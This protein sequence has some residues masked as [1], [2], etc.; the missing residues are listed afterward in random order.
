M[1]ACV[2]DVVTV[3][4]ASVGIW[5][6]VN[7]TYRCLTPTTIGVGGATVTFSDMRLEAYMP[8]NELSPAGETLRMFLNLS[9]QLWMVFIYL[10]RFVFFTCFIITLFTES[11]CMADQTTTTAP[12]TTTSTTTPTTPEPTPEPTPPGLPERGSYSVKTS[13]GTICLLALMGLQL[14]VSYVSQSQNKVT[15]STNFSQTAYGPS[16]VNRD[17]LKQSNFFSFCQ[18]VQELL[19][20]NPNGTSSAGSCGAGSA[21]LVLT[22]EPNTMLSFTFTVV[23]PWSPILFI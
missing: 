3:V 6:Q 22:Q 17:D 21:S 4:S 1:L 2:L 12:T 13:N 15:W 10:F 5:A 9:G 7:T 14:N 8:G 11:V 20:L 18:T 16:L 19:N 23:N